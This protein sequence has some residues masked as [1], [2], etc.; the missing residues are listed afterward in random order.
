[1][2]ARRKVFIDLIPDREHGS[3]IT[4]RVATPALIRNPIAGDRVALHVGQRLRPHQSQFVRQTDEAPSFASCF[5]AGHYGITP[6]ER[7]AL[8]QIDLNP[9]LEAG[10]SKRNQR[11]PFAGEVP[12]VLNPIGR[13]QGRNRTRFVRVNLDG[14]LRCEPHPRAPFD[15]DRL[16]Q[17]VATENTGRR[18]CQDEMHAIVVIR[19]NPADTERRLG[20]RMCQDGA[21]AA[22]PERQLEARMT[23]DAGGSPIVGGYRSKSSWP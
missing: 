18:G 14:R 19:Q 6:D 16:S 3:E 23:P 13:L 20:V 21:A 11:I 1:V 8:R 5:P 7:G 2:K 22:P 15:D 10:V 17:A 12:A 9:L 4:S